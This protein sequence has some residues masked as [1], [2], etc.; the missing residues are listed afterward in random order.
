MTKSS[1]NNLNI[2][3]IKDFFEA[4]PIL[5]HFVLIVLAFLFILFTVIFWLRF[6]TNHGEKIEMPDYIGRNITQVKSDAED[7]SFEIVVT[8][9]VFVVGKSGG[10]IINQ[11]PKPKSWVKSGRK[12]YV[13]ITKFDP[14]KITVAELPI[15]YGNEY[16]QKKNELAYRGIECVIRGKKYDPGEP[17]HILEVY[18]NNELIIDSDVFRAEVEIDKGGVLEFVLSD[19]EGGELLIPDL[20]CKRYT[21]AEFLLQSSKLLVGFIEESGSITA[22]EDSYI[23]A[24]DPV[25]DGITKIKMGSVINLVISQ[26]KPSN[27][28]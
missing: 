11:N 3:Q 26:S 6:Y 2:Q 28:N 8:D 27:C 4:R 16:N 7:R 23:I 14:D 20:R 1:V 22:R 18:Y 19:T 5:K 9:S 15:L 21:E 24:Q 17:N 12:I 10:E 25:A 13:V